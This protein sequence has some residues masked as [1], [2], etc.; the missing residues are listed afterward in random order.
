LSDDDHDGSSR[1]PDDVAASDEVQ[2]ASD[3]R[4]RV[5][6]TGVPTETFRK[7]FSA[8]NSGIRMQPCDAG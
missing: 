1:N 7:K 8:M 3:R 5:T 2:A 4:Q 6:V